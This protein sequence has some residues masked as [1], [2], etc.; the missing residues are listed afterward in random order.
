MLA[1]DICKKALGLGATVHTV[2]S[3][4]AFMLHSQVEL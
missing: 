4:D 2:H 1:G 3:S